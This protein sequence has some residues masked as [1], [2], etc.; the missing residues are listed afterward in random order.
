MEDNLSRMQEMT[1]LD[2]IAMAYV[3]QFEDFK[4]LCFVFP[5]KRAGTFFENS[6]KQF[7][8]AHKRK[9]PAIMTITE[10][11]ENVSGRETASR[12]DLLFRLYNIYK[13]MNHRK[14]LNDPELKIMDFDAFRGWGEIVLSDF[15]EVDQYSVDPSKIFKN[16]KDFKKLESNYLTEDQLRILKDYFGYTPPIGKIEEFWKNAYH[17]RNEDAEYPKIKGK[18]HELWE[19]LA[20]L[21]SRLDE[22]L[23]KDGL[24][25]SGGTYRVALSRLS[26]QYGRDYLKWKRSRWNRVIMVGFN[27]LSITEILIFE[28]LQKLA[29]Q[30][31]DFEVDFFWDCAGPILD[32]E[33]SDA[34]KYVRINK[35]KFPSPK[36]AEKYLQ[37]SERNELPAKLEV[38]ASPSNSAQAKI[39]GEEV[40]SLLK[41]LGAEKINSAKVAVVLPDENLLPVLLHA[42]PENIGEFN[43]TMGYSLKQTS[44]ASFMYHLR[45]LHQR[46][47]KRSSGQR[48][49]YAGDVRMLL[50]HPFSHYLIG[51]E[52]VAKL[53]AM[54]EKGHKITV[55][56]S[57][58]EGVAGGRVEFLNIDRFNDD[59]E[60]VVSYLD[61]LLDRIDKALPGKASGIVKSEIDSSH[62]SHYRDGLKMLKEATDKHNIALNATG[63]FYLV[64]R[65]LA[66]EKIAFEGEPLRGLQ[67]MGLLETRLLD[68]EHIIVLSM[69]DRI[70]PRKSR[71]ASFIPNALRAGYGL[72]RANYQERLFSYYFYRMISRAKSVSLIYDARAGE[73]MRSGGE[74]RYLMQLRYLYAVDKLKESKYRF[75]LSNNTRLPHSVQKSKEIMQ[76]ILKYAKDNS[77]YNLSASAL[78]KYLTCPVKFYYEQIA[79]VNTDSKSDVFI[80]PIT[81]GNIVHDVMLRLYFPESKRT[82]YLNDSERVR[83]TPEDIDR[84]LAEEVNVNGEAKNRI[85]EEVRRSVFRKFYDINEKEEPIPDKE[86]QGTTAITASHLA[87]LVRNVLAYDKGLAPFEL[88]GGEMEGLYRYNYDKSDPSKKVNLKYAIDRLDILQPGSPD[89]KWRIVDYKTGGSHVLAKEFDDIFNGNSDAGNIFQLMLYANIFNLDKNKDEDM[90]L[91]IYQ[92]NELLGEGEACPKFGKV[93]KGAV[94]IEGHKQING[95]FISKLDEILKEIFNPEIDFYPTPNESN[96]NFCKLMQLCGKE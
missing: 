57:D 75:N 20:E 39:A 22:S 37:L 65:L 91:S 73:G 16:V 63:V 44:T 48:F 71:H 83:I 25:T 7:I 90:K 72:P 33:N 52:L 10:F 31:N 51:S 43:L 80:D 21:Y 87:E 15:S 47:S 40:E 61:N 50:S 78:K 4:G 28:K 18:F 86:L 49:F 62:I 46:S 17:K 64:D 29:F 26:E 1:F 30:H 59:T 55:S 85:D 13:E 12:I 74:S 84:L 92:V 58:L 68:F 93:K 53:N 95:E 14:A 32:D 38:I 89:E 54:M 81:Q 88:A 96:C 60:G 8:G 66:G 24:A 82:Q 23:E 36:W 2:A 94:P 5:N 9:L 19:T 77:G 79:K 42:L 35:E 41:E 34:S 11:V 70:M 27:A 56:Y 69:N 6:L 3:N 45:R 67:V 76:N